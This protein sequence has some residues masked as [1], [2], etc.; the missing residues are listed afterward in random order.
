MNIPAPTLNL[1]QFACRGFTL[2]RDNN[3]IL[4]L[5]HDGELITRFWPTQASYQS[6]H[7]ECSRHLALKHG[8]DGCLWS[9]KDGRTN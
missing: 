4:L 6:I 5:L 2:E 3:H 1:G 8:W 7:N 9:R